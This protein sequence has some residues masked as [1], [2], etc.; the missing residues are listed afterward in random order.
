M[1]PLR[2]IILCEHRALHDWRTTYINLADPEARDQ[3]PFIAG[4][5]TAQPPPD[6]E[7]QPAI[8]ET[9]VILKHL[10]DV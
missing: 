6:L 7:G 5:D 3:R 10:G 9:S 8:G 4:W 1:T 2:T